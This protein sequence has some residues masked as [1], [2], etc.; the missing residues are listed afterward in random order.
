MQEWPHP[1]ILKRFYGFLVLV[2]YYEN[3]EKFVKS[4]GQMV[5]GP[6]TSL[7]RN[8]A[9]SWKEENN[10]EFSNLKQVMCTMQALI[11]SYFTKPLSWNVM[12]WACLG[13]ILTQEGRPL[14][15]SSK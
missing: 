3:Y 12:P 9:F 15:F 2:C 4:Y 14:A 1:K 8:N 6:L 5:V 11:V 10:Q 7:I 13:A